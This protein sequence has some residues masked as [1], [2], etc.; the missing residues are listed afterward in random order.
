MDIVF[1]PHQALRQKAKPVSRVD[2]KLYQFIQEFGE[3]L[4]TNER[5]GVGLAAPQVDKQWRMFATYIAA[6]GDRKAPRELTI[7]INPRITAKANNT[8]LGGTEE[9]R[10]LEGC[11]SIPKMYG[12]VP[13]YPWVEIEYEKIQGDRLVST[14]K[15]FTEFPARLVQHELDHLD[16]IL[17]TD[18]ALEY[19]LPIF[20]ENNKEKLVELSEHEYQMV[21]L[22]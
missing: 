2:K 8:E 10:P 5:R 6:E 17:F 16:G 15:K 20:K 12:P 13:R 11:L 4:T 18:H 9:N 1:A 22:Y 14:R 21:E 19:D 3:T 7:F